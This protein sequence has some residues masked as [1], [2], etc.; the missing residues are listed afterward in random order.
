MTKG[1]VPKDWTNGPPVT[2]WTDTAVKA[3]VPFVPKW[4][5]DGKT[6]WVKKVVAT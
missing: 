2:D 1:W 6:V 5:W 4:Y 3:A